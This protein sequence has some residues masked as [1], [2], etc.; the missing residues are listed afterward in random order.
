MVK[1]IMINFSDITSVMISAGQT[2]P[3]SIIADGVIHRY[4][5]ENGTGRVHG[6]SGWYCFHTDGP[7]PVG[8]FG[9]WR[10]GTSIKWVSDE[11]SNLGYLDQM[12]A[13]AFMKQAEENRKQQ[14]DAEYKKAAI[15]A[16]E[17][18]AA[19]KAPTE[20]AY[21]INKNVAA[22][23][24]VKQVGNS[25][26]IP[27]L[28]ESFE[29]Q[30]LQY[31]RP[32]GEKK[33]L[34][35]GK[36]K[37]GFFIIQGSSTILIC[38]GYATGAT[39]H[40]CTGHT[41]YCAFSAGN[42]LAVAQFVKSKNLES[43]IIIC[44]DQDV[45]KP[46]NIGATK[47]T[48]AA[49]AISA[50]V[51]LPE[52][53]GSDFNDLANESGDKAVLQLF[54]GINTISFEKIETAAFE[55]DIQPLKEKSVFPEKLLSPGGMMQ[56]VME[57]ITLSS[58]VSIPEFNLAGAIA[59]IGTLAGHRFQTETKLKTNFYVIALGHA[60]SGKDAPQEAIPA[61][62]L[63][64]TEMNC[65]G[66][67]S[68]P[69]DAALLKYV[70]NQTKARTL[71]FLD[72][73][74][75]MLKSI[76][77]PNSAGY[78]IQSTL[79]KLFS[80]VNRKHVKP[81][82]SGDDLVVHWHHISFYGASTPSHFW[83][84]FTRSDATDGFLARIL[85]FESHQNRVISRR[86]INFDVPKNLIKSINEFSKFGPPPESEIDKN[87]IR[88][89]VAITIPKSHKAE[90]YFLD[91]EQSIIDKQNII[92]EKDEGIAAIYGRAP[93]HAHKLG[94]NHAISLQGTKLKFVEIESVEWAI[95]MM[96]H[97]TEHIITQIRDN[98]SEN[99]WHQHQ[100]RI[101]KAIRRYATSEKPGA[102][103]RDIYRSG[104]K[105]PE[106]I[107]MDLLSSLQASGEILKQ[108]H[109]PNRGRNVDIY[110]I[111]KESV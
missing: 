33:S 58:A 6:K 35:K 3:K 24:G 61:A 81:Y 78:E 82:A 49:E 29:I 39:L 105:V 50:K 53:S 63:Q 87:L 5:V 111:A 57:W 26:V 90:K 32:S 102:S 74:G 86:D 14:Q 12:Q 75:L 107:L 99:D 8:F 51:I 38:E 62:L 73:I 17:I 88:I 37:G 95:D 92:Q 100:Q 56:D 59:M 36:M 9:D 72:E 2:P 25:L 103:I 4:P 66:P 70:A 52:T 96:D 64:S 19:S 10:K 47:A 28:S 84:S 43:T 20:H 16:K 77:R 34:P 1:S 79:M 91:W 41:V 18:Y 42:I 22:Y 54:D 30:S 110:A 71:I 69:S 104:V 68:L 15:S 80:S 93:E 94:L 11:Y 85:I 45:K 97:Q 40:R 46:D 67:Q 106:K 55:I 31:I 101:L 65:I 98:I 13:T 48:F 21:L 27:V 109:K 60:G 7:V 89:P 44:G 83:Q 108:S 76:K 23:P